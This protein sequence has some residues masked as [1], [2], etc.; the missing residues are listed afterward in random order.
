MTLARNHG[1]STTTTTTTTEQKKQKLRKYAT[2]H[3]DN[4][5]SWVD[6]YNFEDEK[7]YSGLVHGTAGCN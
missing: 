5:Q 2:Q 4:S 7:R 3:N 1:S 6:F